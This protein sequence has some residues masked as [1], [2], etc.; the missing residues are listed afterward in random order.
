MEGGRKCHETSRRRL[1]ATKARSNRAVSVGK[2]D[3][4][5]ESVAPRQHACTVAEQN[6][7]ARINRDKVPIG[8]TRLS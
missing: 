1:I 7:T 3:H 4:R 5:V 6:H 2:L 8:L